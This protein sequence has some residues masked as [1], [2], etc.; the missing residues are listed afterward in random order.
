MRQEYTYL[1]ER[2]LSAALGI[3]LMAA[4]HGEAPK[5]QAGLYRTREHLRKQG[6]DEFDVLSFVLR[7]REVFV[8]NRPRAF[9]EKPAPTHR[10]VA[11][12]LKDLVGEKGFKVRGKQKVSLKEVLALEAYLAT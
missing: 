5:L 3:R 10:V 12:S 8:V 7:G 2:A 4:E 9:G 1:L 6:R 11:L